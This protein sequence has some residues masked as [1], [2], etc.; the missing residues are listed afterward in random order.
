MTHDQIATTANGYT[1]S[2]QQIAGEI[3]PAFDADTIHRFRVETKRLRALLRLLQ[4][5]DENLD[6]RLGKRFKEMYGAL[7]EIRDAQM[8]LVRV[9]K[10]EGPSL[11]GYALWLA[12]R[13]GEGQ[14]RWIA[15]YSEKALR[16]LLARIAST[17]WPATLEP[18]TLV[19]FVAAHLAA[20][21][22]VLGQP[23]LHDED[24]H[25]IRKKVKDLQHILRWAKAEWPEGIA[26]LE[27]NN[28]GDIEGLAQRAGDYNDERNAIDTLEVFMREAAGDKEREKAEVVR[29]RWAAVRDENRSALVQDIDALREKGVGL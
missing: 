14:R 29:G 5:A 21:N 6:V 12:S 19:R 17:N 27:A 2:M 22:D 10:D 28:L 13:I 18:E 11:P 1:G 20:I 24:L 26:A 4:T 8:H 16:K 3:A 25:D 15:A 23:A 7:G 9:V